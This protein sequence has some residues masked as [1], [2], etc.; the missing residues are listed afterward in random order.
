MWRRIDYKEEYLDDMIE[1]TI[2]NYGTEETIS[3]KEFV[4][5]E[6]FENPAGDAIIELAL[7][8]ENNILA[9]QYIV[10]PKLFYICGKEYKA[11]LSLNTLTRA[12]YRGKKIFTG[13]AEATYTKAS[14]DGYM[15]CYGAPNP[16]S[17]PGFLKKL[18]FIDLGYMPL[19][20]KPINCS[21]MVMQLF[22]KKWLSI[23]AKPAN[24]FFKSKCRNDSHI[25]KISNENVKILDAFWEKI[26][27]K[28]PVI[29]VRNADYIK[30]RYLNVP[31]RK[32]HP[33]MYVVNG[34][35]VA[36][37]IGRVREVA[38]MQCG[39]IAD[40]I[41]L[42][43]YEKE[44]RI[45]LKYVVHQMELNGASLAGCIMQKNTYEAKQLKKVG[46]MRC[47]DKI[48]PQPTPIIYRK[49]NEGLDENVINDW[50]IW[51]FTTGDYD[52]V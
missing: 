52:V 1:M 46:F 2:E 40:F 21:E 22:G 36:Y 41:F 33:Y 23:L 12:A 17:H 14:E 18:S 16:N 29:G 47:P 19:F 9:G 20:V 43:G 28:Y 4:K 31:I 37:A 11:I 13:L 35:V 24:I 8:E 42:D 45:L 6:Y 51:F 10:N 27:N 30:Y 7:D 34:N 5:H 44:A 49:L 48:L 3:H 25:V 32:Y 50:N 26:K 15:F 39:M 38:N